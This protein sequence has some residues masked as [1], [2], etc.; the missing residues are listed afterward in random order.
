MEKQNI[1]KPWQMGLLSY[2]HGNAVDPWVIESQ[3][4]SRSSAHVNSMLILMKYDQQGMTSPKERYYQVEYNMSPLFTWLWSPCFRQKKPI[5]NDGGSKFDFLL[6]REGK[7]QGTCVNSS[8]WGERSRLV[9]RS[10]NM[11]LTAQNNCGLPHNW[12]LRIRNRTK[13]RP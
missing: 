10:R 9:I 11:G 12:V 4:A 3:D 5:L 1:S 8:E 7:W 6:E 13:I 2:L